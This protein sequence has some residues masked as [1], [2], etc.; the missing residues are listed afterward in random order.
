MENDGYFFFPSIFCHARL[1]PLF[2]KNFS[3]FL[4]L[5]R[6]L[7]LFGFESFPSE[8]FKIW[9]FYQSF[10][11]YY[12]SSSS[13]FLFFFFFLRREFLSTIRCWHFDERCALES[14][15]PRKKSCRT[16]VNWLQ[17][18]AIKTRRRE[19]N[20]DCCAFG[21][22]FNILFACWTMTWK[23]NRRSAFRMDCSAVG[24]IPMLTTRKKKKRKKYINDDNQILRIDEFS[25]LFF[26]DQRENVTISLSSRVCSV[27]WFV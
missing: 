8:Y 7:F 27:G 15:E 21:W 20:A 26:V 12:Y 1:F 24:D 14:K 10:Y 4:E 2:L 19:K 25:L 18:G 13:M 5:P 3:F 6:P 17:E 23:W 16:T 9:D 11:Y 22:L